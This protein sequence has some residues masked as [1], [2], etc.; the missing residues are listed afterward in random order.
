MDYYKDL[1]ELEEARRIQSLNG[2]SLILWD[3]QKLNKSWG[4]VRYRKR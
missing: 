1:K 4:W 3:A 2:C